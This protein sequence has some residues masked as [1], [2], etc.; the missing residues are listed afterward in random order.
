MYVRACMCVWL[1]VALCVIVA[2]AETER[3]IG[4]AA[5][6]QLAMN[7]ENTVF[8]AKRL[9]GRRFTDPE[10]QANM[11]H[12]P[13]QVVPGASDK[14][15]I[16]VSFGGERRQFA[17]QEISAMVLTK[18]KETAEAYLGGEVKNAVITVPT[19]FNDAQRQLT[20]DAG[21]IAG[22]NVLRIINEPTAAAIAY[23]LDKRDG[24]RNALIFDLGGGTLDVSLL[25][26][27]DGI[28]EVKA[29]AGDAHLGGQDFD[30]RL[31]EH[32]IEDFQRKFRRDMSGNARARRR[33]RSACERAKR[34]LSLSR[35][36]SIEVDSLFEGCDYYTS[37]SR[38]MFEEMNMEYFRRALGPVERVLAEAGLAKERVHD[39]VL[40]GGSSRIPRVQAMLREFF[41]GKE[42]TG[43]INADE[44]VAYGAAVQV[45]SCVYSCAF[46]CVVVVVWCCVRR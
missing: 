10:V 38:A 7:P 27:E 13:F 19:Y 42:L 43:N 16:E 25:T 32:C 35:Q 18:M 31:V 34:A 17:P 9:L 26:I 46:V 41:D 14:P 2:C 3:L 11:R 12:W 24:E 4:D 40:V 6:N 21:N 45:C 1:Y 8:D 5:K 36:A 44:A 23:G 30:N 15:L 29:T 33:L 20:K 28:F 22:L 39:V 37:I